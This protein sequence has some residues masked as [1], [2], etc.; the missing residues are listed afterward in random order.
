MRQ[1]LDIKNKG[2]SVRGLRLLP[3]YLF[4]LINILV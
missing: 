3:F 2:K 4:T 1:L